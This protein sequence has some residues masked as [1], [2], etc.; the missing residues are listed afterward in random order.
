MEAT[1]P[2]SCAW[3]DLRSVE[4]IEW[5]LWATFVCLCDSC[6]C[7]VDLPSWSGPPWNGDVPSWAKE[8]APKIQSLGWSMAPDFFNLLCPNCRP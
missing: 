4:A 1:P 8:H 6:G 5:A 2:E 7:E 3:E